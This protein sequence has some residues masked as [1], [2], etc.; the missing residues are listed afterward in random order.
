MGEPM[1]ELAIN[2]V[3]GISKLISILIKGRYDV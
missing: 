3:P 2:I 1:G